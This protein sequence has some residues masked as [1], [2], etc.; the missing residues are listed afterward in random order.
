MENNA[1]KDKKV[2]IEGLTKMDYI[3]LDGK[4]LDEFFI[5][6]DKAHTFVQAYGS[7]ENTDKMRRTWDS[8]NSMKNNQIREEEFDSV[9]KIMSDMVGSL[10]KK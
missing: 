10:P 1:E 7:K 2:I 5:I 3:S 4:K 6:A 8:I 9:K